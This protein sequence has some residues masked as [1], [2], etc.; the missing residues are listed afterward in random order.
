[1]TSEETGLRSVQAVAGSPLADSP[2]GRTI[3]T[4]LTDVWNDSCAVD[5][6]EYAIGFGATGATANPAI[7]TDVWRAAP[8]TWR[9]RVADLA[10]RKPEWS[11]AD[12]AWAVVGE[13]S[14]RGAHLLEDVFE[15][16]GGRK[17][18]LSMQTDPTLFGSS[19]RML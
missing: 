7:G 3:A 18:R 2:L 8:D 19:D 11:E 16:T 15:A 6:L 1:M 14:V 17:G 4:T 5:E 12:L 13:M 9:A 10:V